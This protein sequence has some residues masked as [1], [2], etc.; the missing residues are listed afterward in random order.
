MANTKVMFSADD[1]LA[2]GSAE[3]GLSDFGPADHIE[4]LRMLVDSTNKDIALSAMGT[5]A[6]PAEVHR[7][8]VNRLRFADYLKRHPEILNED[9]SD[10]IVVF[11]LPRSG[12]TKLQR[13]MSAD[14]GVQSLLYWRLVNPA[15]FPNAVPG[16]EDPRIEAGRQAVAMMMQVAPGFLASHPTCYD[17]ADEETF[18]M[19][20]SF[21]CV[22]N[23]L[24]QPAQ[25]YYTWLR[26]QSR[27]SMYVYLKQ[28]LQYLQWQ[29]GGRRGR[30]WILKSPVHTENLD[31][32]TELFPKVTV[33]FTH[34]D[35][36]ATIASFCRLIEM[37]WAIKQDNP[38]LHFIGRMAI[39]MWSGQ[40][41][42]HVSQREALGARANVI[43]VR[44]DEVKD[45]VMAVLRRV[46]QRAGR[47]LT[48][49]C[50]QA[51]LAWEADN[52]PG[53]LGTYTYTLER[54]GLSPAIIEERFGGFDR[55]FNG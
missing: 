31:L 17:Q 38:D 47:E 20:L 50:E 23:Y 4:A 9:V 53:K 40:L 1:M 21:R 12:T 55:R 30:P 22:L 3:T 5:M 2:A 11:G 25:G 45:D 6:F 10:P 52:Q 39:E 32:I 48:P 19:I 46:Y 29:D 37:A 7:V 33:V 43:D 26:Q 16:A 28:L 8:L 15:T 35:Y 13:M 36:K 14:P 44:Y 34:R 24:L 41:H 27:R 42:T 51:M 49:Q 18:L 54:Y